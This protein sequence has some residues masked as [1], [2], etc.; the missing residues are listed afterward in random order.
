MEGHNMVPSSSQGTK[1]VK[2]ATVDSA[3]H[4]EH[5]YSPLTNSNGGPGGC[6]ATMHRAY[7]SLQKSA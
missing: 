5:K 1:P 2:Q 3:V 4:A 7:A 6:A